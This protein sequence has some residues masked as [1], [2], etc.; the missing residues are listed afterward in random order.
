M[1]KKRIVKISVITLAVL[2][3]L[4]GCGVGLYYWKMNDV[5]HDDFNTPDSVVVSLV[6]NG[7]IAER[8]LSRTER[9]EVIGLF[10]DFRSVREFGV[11]PEIKET[12][13]FK[14]YE[15]YG[16]VKFLYRTDQQNKRLHWSYCACGYYLGEEEILLTYNEIYFVVSDGYIYAYEGYNGTIQHCIGVYVS[17]A[18]ER[19]AFLS[20]Y[21]FEGGSER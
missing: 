19:Q 21:F 17:E 5:L 7:K 18:V 9:R 20:R 4:G 3:L 8:E 15:Q 2:L 11:R 1:T 6:E 13:F 16:A 10:R 12:A 14:Q